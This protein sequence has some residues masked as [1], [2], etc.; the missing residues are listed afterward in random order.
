MKGRRSRISEAISRLGTLLALG[1]I[2]SACAGVPSQE[3]SDARRAVDAARES[4]AGRH[5]PQMMEQASQSLGRASIALRAGDYD[6]ARRL[7]LSARDSAI[8]ARTVGDAVADAEGAIAT[9]R[10]AGRPVDGAREILDLA[11]DAAREGN[12]DRA[13]EMANRASE[14][15]R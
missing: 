2:L 5:A 7:A 6:K 4:D 13:L 10:A 1:V 9:A 12:T 3:M 8:T 15:A 14:L 11:L